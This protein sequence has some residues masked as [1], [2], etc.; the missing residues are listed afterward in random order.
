MLQHYRMEPAVSSNIS[1]NTDKE[2]AVSGCMYINIFK[3][4]EVTILWYDKSLGFFPNEFSL[5]QKYNPIKLKIKWTTCLYAF[6]VSSWSQS[7]HTFMW[8]LKQ[9]VE[10]QL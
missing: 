10:L 1:H 5:K 4:K 3:I 7:Q 2:V 8:L 6:P 9:T